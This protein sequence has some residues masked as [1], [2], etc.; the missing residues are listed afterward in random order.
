M[1]RILRYLRQ[2]FSAR[3]SLWVVM[4]ATLIF[5]ATLGVMFVQSRRAVR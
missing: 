2:S 5:L 3:L 1:K 4:F